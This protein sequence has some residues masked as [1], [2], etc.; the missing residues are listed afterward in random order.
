MYDSDIHE[1]IC[2]GKVKI[3]TN[4]QKLNY[5]YECIFFNNKWSA[6]VGIDID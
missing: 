4:K 2:V 1:E 6:T 5:R 3:K